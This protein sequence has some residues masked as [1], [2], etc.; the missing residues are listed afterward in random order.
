MILMAVGPAIF[1]VAPMNLTEFEAGRKITF[2]EHDV[3]GA[4]QVLE[5]TGMNAATLRVTGKLLPDVFGDIRGLDAIVAAKLAGTPVPVIR[6][7]YV[8]LGWFVIEDSDEKHES[9]G[10]T[11]IGREIIVSLKLKSVGTPASSLA[12]AIFSLIG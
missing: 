6:G 4:A 7:D 11:G 12:S 10:A 5:K 1:Q 8:P 9:V 2:A 3:L